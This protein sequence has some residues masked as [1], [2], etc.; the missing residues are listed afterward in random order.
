[1]AATETPEVD[2]FQ[3][4]GVLVQET[5]TRAI[6]DAG[7]P[8]LYA[9]II[10]INEY[11]DDKVPNLKGAVHD[12]QSFRDYLIQDLFVP[13][14]QIKTL[15]GTQ[16]TRANIINE[17]RALATNTQINKQDPIVVFYAGHGA[18]LEKPAGWEAGG[19]SI[20]ALVP[21]D[22]K[23]KDASGAIVHPIPDR[24]IATLLNEIGDAKGDNITVIFDCCHSASGT[25]D[26]VAPGRFARYIDPKDLLPL[27]VDIDLDILPK[28]SEKPKRHAVV[29][30]GFVYQELRNH[31]LLAACG[32]EELAYE[33]DGMGDFTA[34]LLMTLK[35]YG[36]DKT[37]YKGC[38]QRLP[39]LQKQNPQCEGFHKERIFFNAQVAGANRQMILIEKQGNRCFL[40]AGIAQNI[41][42]GAIFKVFKEDIADPAKDS[43]IGS[44][45]VVSA[46][47]TSSTLT[48]ADDSKPFNLPDFSYGFQSHC[49][50]D[51]FLKVHFTRRLQA[52]LPLDD[53]WYSAFTANQTN[54]VIKPTGPDTADVVV[55]LDKNNHAVFDIKHAL[56]N[57]HGVKELP[58]AVPVTAEDI[59]AVLRAAALWIWHLNRSNPESSLEQSIKFEFTKV[60]REART[61]KLDSVGPDLN[62][63]G[64]VEIVANRRDLYGMKIINT[65][66]YNLYPYL[67]YFDVNGQSIEKWNDQVVG[68]T[69]S[70]APLP[71]G[72]FL[73]IGYGAGG[74]T[75]FSFE[76]GKNRPLELG[77]LKLY[78][79]NLPSEFSSIEHLSPF[80]FDEEGKRANVKTTDVARSLAMRGV[81][82]TVTV[83]LIQRKPA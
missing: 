11:T 25:R 48:W 54:I 42:V 9:L 66:P 28:P 20:Q 81:W 62:H 17:F 78:V 44:L 60:V 69:H 12:A 51:Q 80:T 37:T 59:L 29:A 46:E 65:S 38:I 34:A 82:H 39:I 24:T 57:R 74:A 52:R 22:V 18:Q 79:T 83:A 8:P 1:M 5:Q 63:S 70:D 71:K 68:K 73:T 49:G 40:R 53:E 77:I 6:K 43:P 58:E 4:I 2:F 14:T 3:R 50:S 31:V 64:V 16:A 45:R 76:V 33:T 10:G 27:P 21:Q 13:Q 67:F 41:G 30:Q 19:T 72:S 35:Q 61:R 36:A 55:D 15:F 23:R 47:P 32:S 26:I 7:K 56:V 75:P